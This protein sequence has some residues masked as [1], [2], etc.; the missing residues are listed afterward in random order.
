M[1]FTAN[2]LLHDYMQECSKPPLSGSKMI[3]RMESLK[4]K[5]KV[6]PVL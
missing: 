4:G 5:G 6:V 3:L 1:L 2:S